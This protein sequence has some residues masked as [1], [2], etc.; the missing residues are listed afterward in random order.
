MRALF[1]STRGAGHFN[2]LVSFARAFERAGHEVMFAGPPDLAGSAEAAGFRFRQFDPPPE[3]ELGAIWARVPELPPDEANIVVIGDIFGRLNTNAALPGLHAALGEWR[4]DVVLRDPNEYGS[5]IAAEL[6]GIPHARVAISLASTEELGLGVARRPL[7]AIRR[8]EGLPPDPDAAMLRA[9]P[10]LTTFPRGLDEGEMPDTHRFRDPAWEQPGERLP[11]WW[12]GREDQPL[13]YVTFGS[14]AGSFPQALPAY[15]VALSAVAD[16][17]ARVLL[18]VGRDLDPGALPNVP[19]NV[20]VE[21]W[22]PQQDVLAHA[23]A[24]VVHGGSGS[25]LGALAAGV[26][27]VV[28]PLFA[29]QPYNARRV[30]E[31]GAGLAVEPNRDDIPATIPPLRAAIETVLSEPSYR[32]R[33]QALAE[34]LRNE[35]PVDDA[36]ALLKSIG[37]R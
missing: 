14:V 10:W 28:I 9:S 18:T 8:A 22:V 6:H 16:V 27:L 30:A 7:D 4:P 25:T 31:V 11:D 32:A 37:R 3:D 1:S 5:A 17:P 23:A 15:G 26:P 19:D 2:P 36:V 33:A 29:D 35:R 21:Q 12:P 20:H 13:V 34:E 24:A